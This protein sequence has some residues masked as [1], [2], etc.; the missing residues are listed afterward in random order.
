M[1]DSSVLTVDNVQRT[2]QSSLTT[3]VGS[4]TSSATTTV[5]GSTGS[6]TSDKSFKCGPEYIQKYP[7]WENK[8]LLCWLDTALSLVVLNTSFQKHIFEEKKQCFLSLIC[9][10]YSKIQS[11][12]QIKKLYNHVRKHLEE[13]RHDAL[14]FLE[15]KLL[16]KYNE[17]D[18]PLFSLPLLLKTDSKLYEKLEVNYRTQFKCQKCQF[19]KLNR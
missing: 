16:T 17:E 14:K 19:E 18:S 1:R 9:E 2:S 10:E 15:P 4:L 13:I 6:S 7:L 5:T 12:Y 11:V 3:S 8:G